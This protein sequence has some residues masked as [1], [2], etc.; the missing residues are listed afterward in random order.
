MTE[1]IINKKFTGLIDTGANVSIR[2]SEHW[3]VEWPKIQIP[4][5]FSGV[6]TLEQFYPSKNELQC[7]SEQ[8]TIFFT[9]YIANTGFILWGRD[10]LEKY[11]TQI[12]IRYSKANFN[13]LT[14]Q[15]CIASQDLGNPDLISG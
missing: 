8:Q 11:N 6:G 4:V 1:V 5:S 10:L 15:G 3:P 12:Y 13:V 14:R 2:A 9:P 7:T